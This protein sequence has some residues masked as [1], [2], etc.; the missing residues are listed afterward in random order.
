MAWFGCPIGIDAVW[1][2]CR[3][4]KVKFMSMAWFVIG[5]PVSVSFLRMCGPSSFVVVLVLRDRVLQG[6]LLVVLHVEVVRFCPA[7]ESSSAGLLLS[8]SVV[9]PALLGQ[10]LQAVQPRLLQVVV[11]VVLV[12]HAPLFQDKLPAVVP[13]EV[14]RSRPAGWSPLLVPCCRRRR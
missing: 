8:S 7:G 1:A 12:V 3:L 6:E 5:F 14:V 9:V 13:F 2:C 10:V 4:L 11:V